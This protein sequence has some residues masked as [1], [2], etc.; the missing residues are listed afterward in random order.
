MGVII[1][2]FNAKNFNLI[3]VR[4]R[5]ISR[6][7]GD[8]LPIR[9]TLPCWLSEQAYGGGLS[10]KY[11]H[12]SFEWWWKI[13]RKLSMSTEHSLKRYLF[14][15]YLLIAKDNPQSPK[16]LH[17]RVFLYFV[18]HVIRLGSKSEFLFAFNTDRANRTKQVSMLTILVIL[19][20]SML[21]SS[22]DNWMSLIS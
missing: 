21:V 7:I 17:Y 9:R 5:H 13:K 6:N 4:R 15:F 11:G 10:N 14:L 22:V 12:G 16:D 2:N 20:I 19:L 18:D 3:R 8:L 1:F